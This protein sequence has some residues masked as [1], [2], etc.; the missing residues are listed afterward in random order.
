MALKDKLM[1]GETVVHES[2]KHWIAPVRDSIVPVLLLVGAVILGNIAPSGDGVIANLMRWIQI[3]LVVAGVAM[4]AYN[5]LVWRTAIFA[6][7]N[8]RVIREEGLLARRSSAT[9]IESITDVRMNIPFIGSRLHYGDLNIVTSSGEAGADQFRTIRDPEG[10]RDHILSR[11]MRDDSPA[12]SPANVVPTTTA[13]AT[14]APAAPT[15][16][17][18]PPAATTDETQTLERLAEL[19]DNGVITAEEYEAKKAEILSRI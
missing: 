4:I 7:T 1:A 11:E 5:L 19:R 14:P 10:F 9:L 18:A 15:A 6:V 12:P 2:Q 13:T 17:P 3:G 8:R 16:T